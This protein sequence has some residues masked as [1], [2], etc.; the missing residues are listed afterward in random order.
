MMSPIVIVLLN[1]C[2]VDR[3]RDRSYPAGIYAIARNVFLSENI[4]SAFYS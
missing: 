2:N 1:T 4:Y 3:S